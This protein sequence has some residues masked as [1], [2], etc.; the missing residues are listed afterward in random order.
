M[1]DETLLKLSI[2]ASVI[3]ILLIVFITQTMEVKAVKISDIKKSMSGDKIITY[4]YVNSVYEKSGNMFINIADNASEILV[5]A[6]KN[7]FN[8]KKG[9]YIKVKGKV[10]IYKNRLE[11]IA[12]S[13]N[14]S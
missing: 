14:R 13:I 12:D 4:G 2:F 5:V 6:F 11:I 9:D 10:N 3:G 7:H 1:R 8:I